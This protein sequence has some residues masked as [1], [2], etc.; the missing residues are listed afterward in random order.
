MEFR[1]QKPEARR[2]PSETGRNNSRQGA[3]ESVCRNVV[4]QFQTRMPSFWLLASGFWLLEF[5][6]APRNPD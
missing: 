1:S 5:I 4:N 3:D 6:Q 2:K